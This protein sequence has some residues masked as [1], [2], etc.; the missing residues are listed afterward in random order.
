M[1]ARGTETAVQ[2]GFLEVH[3]EDRILH[4]RRGETLAATLT[5]HGEK[6]LRH[7][8]GNASRGLFCGMGVCQDC[9]VEVDGMPNQRACMTKV[10]RPMNV[11]R[12]AAL[13]ALAVTQD[14]PPPVPPIETV[15]EDPDV[16]VIGG[17]AGGLNAAIAAVR[18]GARVVLVDERPAAG[19]QYFKQPHDDLLAVARYR[20]DTQFD[21][22]R[23]LIEQA[24]RDGVCF[25]SGTVWNVSAALETAVFDGVRTRTF[26]P[27]QM[28]VAT[29]AYERGLAVPGWT[30]PGVMTTG[31]A[32]T[33]LRSYGVVPGARVLV[34][35]NGPLNLQ[36]ATELCAAGAEIV[37]VAELS[38]R[39]GPGALRSIW[40]MMRTAPD[41]LL[42]GSRYIRDLKRS[43]I[44]IHYG[45]VLAGVEEG[46]GGLAATIRSQGADG[47]AQTCTVD[48]VLMGYG[49]MPS[50]EILRLLGCAHT[51][52]G[53]CGHL[54]TQRDEACRT[55]VADVF[56]IGDCCGLGGA[57][58]AISEGIIA[59]LAAAEAAGFDVSPLR[60]QADT[61]RRAL[62]RQRRFQ[63]ALW[64]VFAAPHPGTSLADAD[65]I[66]CR[67]EEISLLDI[68]TAITEGGHS[69]SEIKRLT[70]LG[71]GR[72]QGRYCAPALADLVAQRNGEA[73][74]EFTY[75]APRPPI[76]PVPLGAI[77]ARDETEL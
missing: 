46:E 39:P 58:A 59:G 17:G 28:V 54:T 11:R 47:M 52:D 19:G 2:Q 73:I 62:A 30:L 72:C 61:A 14:A 50:N 53:R 1:R 67:C 77:S 43:G 27:K 65:T 66:I 4:A 16:L 63:E 41:L 44:S 15:P 3:F 49:F 36:V 25:F 51:Y 60:S 7:T 55:S 37:A 68:E 23:R 5:A 45:H 8:A 20:D 22:G 24:E 35:G 26:R 9:L 42:Q 75:F 29:G 32:Q 57:K 31:A 71:M 64:T 48:A 12:Q 76:K 34:A 6:S 21:G 70:R 56:A 74:D 69:M 38:A 18:A 33:L 10:D 40:Q 13:P